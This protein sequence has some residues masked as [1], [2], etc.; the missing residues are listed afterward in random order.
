MAKKLEPKRPNP[1]ENQSKVPVGMP[2]ALGDVEGDIQLDDEHDPAAYLG[3]QY[4]MLG[5]EYPEGPW[6]S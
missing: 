1:Q 5:D 3:D 4:I 6:K 2:N